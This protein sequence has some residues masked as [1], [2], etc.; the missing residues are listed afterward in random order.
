MKIEVR[1]EH[2]EKGKRNICNEYDCPVALA[3]MERG[4][5]HFYVSDEL[6]ASELKGPHILPSKVHDFIASFD[7][8]EPVGPISFV[9]PN[10]LIKRAALSGG[11]TT[12]GERQ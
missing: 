7:R 6:E 12:R 1:Q 5:T 9:I 3:V 4:F 11:V 2:I 8:G 10:R